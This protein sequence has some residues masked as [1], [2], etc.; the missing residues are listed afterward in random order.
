MHT[1]VIQGLQTYTKAGL[2]A[3]NQSKK[4]LA[5]KRKIQRDDPSHKVA[6][7]PWYK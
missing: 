4:I 2:G 1:L 3:A 6:G 7:I 5:L